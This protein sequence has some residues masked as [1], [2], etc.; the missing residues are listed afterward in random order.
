MTARLVSM[1][2]VLS[3]H[4]MFSSHAISSS[5]ASLSWSILS[6]LLSSFRRAKASRDRVSQP[7]A[8]LR[9]A[10]SC[11]IHEGRSLIISTS[12]SRI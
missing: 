8:S 10:P 6:H 1:G 9:S 3:Y 7:A 12:L 11:A 5:S 2:A 4:W